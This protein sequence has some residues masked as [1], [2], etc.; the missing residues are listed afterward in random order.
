MKAITITAFDTP[1]ALDDLPAP[2]PAPN[3]VLVRVHASSVNPV[4]N[5]IAAGLL[6]Q[7][8]V[9][10]DFPV[11]IGRDYAGVVAEVGAEVGSFAVGDQV[12]GFLLHANPTAHDGSWA[13][14][15]TVPQDISIAKAPEGVDLAAAGAAPLAG[16]T[17]MLSIDALDLAEGDTVLIVGATGGVGSLAVQLAARAGATVVAPALP[18]DEDYLRDLGVSE[19][20]PRDDDLDAAAR[21]RRPDGFDAVLDLVNYGP[22]VPASLV[23]DGGR[24]ASPTGAAG[25]GTGR[26]MVMAAP[27]SENLQRLAA[28]LAATLRVPIH[29]TYELVQAPDALTALA[30]THTQGKLAVRV[31]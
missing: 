27:T 13:E 18:E 7:M 21:E 5:G 20:L 28:L 12:F 24:I 26:T 14:L 8:G 15:I 31:G 17:A 30:T 3:E 1:P 19:L 2:T 9:E 4:D 23:K 29:A 10:Y 11:V 22:D 6:E 25:E 16:I